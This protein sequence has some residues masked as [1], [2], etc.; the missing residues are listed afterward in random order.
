[1][2]PDWRRGGL[3]VPDSRNPPSRRGFLATVPRLAG[4]GAAFWA[5]V[6]RTEGQDDEIPPRQGKARILLDTDAANYFDDQFA[7]AYA[8]LSSEAI[9]IEALYAA[10]FANQRVSDP[11]EGMERSYEEIGRV[12]DALSPGRGIPVLRGSPTWMRDDGAPIESPA[13]TDIV[14]R[15]MG[16]EP[17]IDY[18]VAIG[19]ATTVASALLM[20]PRVGQR[21]TVIWLGGTPHHF[22]SASEF[23]LRQDPAAVRVLFNSGTRLVHVPAP[24][25]AEN[26]RVSREELERRMRG[27]SAIGEYLL[28][29]VRELSPVH[30]ESSA[31]SRTQA[32]WDMAAVAWLVNPQWVE[33]ALVPSPLLSSDLAW[34][35][36]PYRHRIRVATRVLRDEVFTDFFRKIGTAPD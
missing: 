35:Q 12:L 6:A 8:A 17:E 1:M 5:S 3:D 23:N 27:K 36:S 28:D 16:G 31:S 10:P 24:G 19:A 11:A 14:E 13:A 9:Q 4:V 32:I 7:L 26:V 21:S 25:L 18:V 2:E 15:V 20:E 33:S 34:F 30:Q 22:A 29:I